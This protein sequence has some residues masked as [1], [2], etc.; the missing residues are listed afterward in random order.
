MLKALVVAALLFVLYDNKK[1]RAKREVN[2]YLETLDLYPAFEKIK[3][4]IDSSVTPQQFEDAWKMINLFKHKYQNINY[5][6]KLRE[7]F[8]AVSKLKEAYHV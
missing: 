8:F 5:T 1:L 4:I 2:I 6:L 7:M 3:S